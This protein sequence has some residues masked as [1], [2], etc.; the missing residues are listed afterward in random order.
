[1]LAYFSELMK[2]YKASSLW[3]ILSAIKSVAKTKPNVQ[4]GELETVQAIL[5]RKQ[6][7]EKPKKA[8]VFTRDEIDKFFQEAQGLQYLV[9]KLNML[10]GIAGALRREELYWLRFRDV[11]IYQDHLMINIPSSK[12]DQAGNGRNF[13][14]LKDEEHPWKCPL[15][16]YT[17]YLD[18]LGFQLKP[19]DRLWRQYRDKFTRQVWGINNIGKIPKKIAQFLK[20]DNPKTYSGHAFR[21]TSATIAADNGIDMI[22]LKRLGGW[23]S[24]SVA[25]GYIDESK[26]AKKKN[27]KHNPRSRTK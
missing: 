19:N 23:K 14:I 27:C 2:K 11:S 12:T 1:M 8:A 10:F 21:R 7:K 4:L 20:L 18:N 22:N 17:T 26:V 6:S 5:K 24:D 16:L 9:P 3:T 15:K 13:V 25:Q